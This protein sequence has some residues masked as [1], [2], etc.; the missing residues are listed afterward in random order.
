M[1]VQSVNLISYPG[2]RP[3]F[4]SLDN[5][6]MQSTQAPVGCVANSGILPSFIPYIKKQ[7]ASILNL[8]YFQ[9]GDNKPD[10]FQ[11][12]AA[13]AIEQGLNV[14]VPAPT[15][16]GKTAVAF[17]VTSKNMAEGKRTF[18]TAPLKA[19][20]NQKIREFQ[21]KYG[22]NNVGILTGDVKINPDAPILIMTTEIYTNMLIGERINTSSRKSPMDNL[23]SVIFDE[24]HYLNDFERGKTWELAMILTPPD[25]QVVSLSATVGNPKQIVNWQNHI[26]RS[27]KTHLVK[28]SPSDRPVKLQETYTDVRPSTDGILPSDESFRDMVKTLK[29]E[30]RVPAIFFVPSKK[31]NRHLVNVFSTGNDADVL[32]LTT[33]KEKKIIRKIIDRNPALEKSVNIRAL[34]RGYA[35]H[36]AGMLPE[37]K[38]IV[39]KMFQ[40][41]LIKVIFATETLSAG[42]NMPA[43]SVVIASTQ[44]P[45]TMRDATIGNHRREFTATEIQQMAGRA[46]RRGIDKEGFVY[47]MCCQD[48]DKELFHTL[49]HAPPTPLQSRL[50]FDYSFIAGCIDNPYGDYLLEEIAQ[51]SMSHYTSDKTSAKKSK[52]ELLKAIETSKEEM[53]SLGFLTEEGTLTFKGKLLARLNGYEQLPVINVIHNKLLV[54]MSAPELAAC[55]GMMANAGEKTANNIERDINSGFDVGYDFREIKANCRDGHLPNILS[56]IDQTFKD[57]SEHLRRFGHKEEFDIDLFKRSCNISHIG[58][59]TRSANHLLTWADYNQRW[60]LGTMFDKDASS[61]LWQAFYDKFHPPADSNRVIYEEGHLF[62]EIA[63]TIDLLEQIDKMCKYALSLKDV[64]DKNYYINLRQTATEAIK[65]LS[66]GPCKYCVGH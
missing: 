9:L 12:D 59:D 10:R 18:Y 8:N 20:S 29:D 15:G 58:V 37:T 50:N 47:F 65:L 11:K 13:K 5:Q 16:C 33:A 27:R 55:V 40:E 64:P 42:L 62:R 48:M 24:M 44:K 23:G 45:T 43:K 51:K 56:E 49:Y 2:V 46:G 57:T 25:T 19:L 22:K 28:V 4:S 32:D 1:R 36:N 52:Q 31:D 21:Q 35:M 41:R 17:Y 34:M 61:P 66:H 60:P 14:L 38:E 53:K 7:S 63:Q 3:R 30:K 6:G 54:G 39:E 26:G